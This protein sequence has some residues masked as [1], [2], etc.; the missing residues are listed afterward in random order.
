MK[1]AL[2]GGVYNNY[3]ALETAAQDA[4]NRGCD[5]IYCLGD[6]GAFGPSPDKVFPILEKYKIE[7]VQGNYDDSVGNNLEDCQCG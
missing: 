2:I 4:I 7:T 1:I 5:K 3:I 6:L